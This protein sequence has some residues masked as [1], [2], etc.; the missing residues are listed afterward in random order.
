MTENNKQENTGI[1]PSNDL[2]AVKLS[3]LARRGLEMVA[4][5]RPR[6]LHVPSEY[7]SVEDAVAVANDGDIIEVAAGKYEVS[8][9]IEESITIRGLNEG[10]VFTPHLTV[11]DPYYFYEMGILE[12][13][14][15][16]PVIIE[17]DSGG[18]EVKLQNIKFLS[19]DTYYLEEIYLSP[20]IEFKTGS[21]I[22]ENCEFENFI[23]QDES[24]ALR[25]V[26]TYPPTYFYGSLGDMFF[27][28]TI[29]IWGD[30]GG[31]NEAKLILKNSS[32][33]ECSTCI[34]AIGIDNLTIEQCLFDLEENSE[35]LILEGLKAFIR[36][37]LFKK[38]IVFTVQ[39][40]SQVF[41]NFDTYYENQV[42]LQLSSNEFEDSSK[43]QFDHATIVNAISLAD[44]STFTPE[45]VK[46]DSSGKPVW[47]YSYIKFS[48]SILTVLNLETRLEEVYHRNPYIEIESIYFDAMESGLIQFDNANII[49]EAFEDT[50][51][52][53]IFG[54]MEKYKISLLPDSPA[55]GAASDGLNLGAWQGE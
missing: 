46:K 19:D 55:I 21:L 44:L 45:S 6:I 48:N 22:I 26:T 3:E 34:W 51:A 13:D 29:I 33:K 12:Y 27:L 32:F 24:Q 17:V 52:K 43:A 28:P 4:Q 35:G 23:M 49:H 7:K 38:G 54:V 10:V 18:G 37:S 25:F 40:S 47:D 16:G 42:I 39:G 8:V 53:S 30:S 1:V 2:N 15:F 9:R 20:A 14:E 11:P 5:D 50:E 31:K 41:S 36:D